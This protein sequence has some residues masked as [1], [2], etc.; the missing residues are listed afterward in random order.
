[1]TSIVVS[2]IM[3]LI[4]VPF[5]PNPFSIFSSGVCLGIF[6]ARVINEYFER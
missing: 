4:N 3:F 1:M 2:F 6:I 5:F